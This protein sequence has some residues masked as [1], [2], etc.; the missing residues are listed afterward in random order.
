MI[1]KTTNG[2]SVSIPTKEID[3]LVSTL[4][5]TENEAVE[6][7]LTDNGYEENEEQVELDEKASKVRIDKDAYT[8]TEKKPRK[9]PEIKVSDEKKALFDSILT[10]LTRCEGVELENIK[11]LNENKLISVEINGITFKIDL[12]QCRKG[13]KKA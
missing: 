9:K 4:G 8:E 6:L 7:W 5:I 12:V 13:K 3:S 1:Y 10:N 2:K 11:V